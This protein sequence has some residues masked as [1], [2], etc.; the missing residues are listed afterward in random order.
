MN[1]SVIAVYPGTFDPIT[2]GHEDIIRRAAKLFPVV[3]VGVA[4][5]R[6]KTPLF[7]L[8]ERV[9]MVQSACAEYDSIRVLPLQALVCDFARSQGA[10]AMIRGVRSVADF[11]Y[12]QQLAGMNRHLAPEIE[13]VLIYPRDIYQCISS[14]LV[15]EIDALGGEVAAFVSASVAQRLKARRRRV[16]E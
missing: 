2:L 11:D 13:T 7:S 9:A 3:I 6:H 16:A 15:R 5:G 4:T 8:D 12:E 1:N 14:T 10:S